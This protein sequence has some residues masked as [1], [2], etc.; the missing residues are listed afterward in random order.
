MEVM[1]RRCCGRFGRLITLVLLL[2]IVDIHDTVTATTWALEEGAL[3][4]A[5][6]TETKEVMPDLD[7]N[8]ADDL[9]WTDAH[10]AAYGSAIAVGSTGVIVPQ[11]RSREFLEQLPPQPEHKS[12]LCRRNDFGQTALHLAVRQENHGVVSLYAEGRLPCL[13]QGNNEG[14]TPLHYAAAWGRRAA[15]RILLRGGADPTLRNDAGKTPM[16]EAIFFGHE[17]IWSLM[18]ELLRHQHRQD[19]EL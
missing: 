16:D 13:D 6:E 14:D 3:A 8:R 9:G 2:L 4:G 12:F 15:A 5:G 7:T 18:D 1:T 17:E 11:H 19:E 10:H